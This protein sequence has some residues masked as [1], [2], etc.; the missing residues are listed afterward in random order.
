MSSPILAALAE[1]RRMDTERRVRRPPFEYPPR[2][3][4]DLR[5]RRA[6]VAVR[7]AITRTG[8]RRPTSASPRNA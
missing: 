2:P 8:R 6:I 5:V 7:C 1:A 4:R 3:H